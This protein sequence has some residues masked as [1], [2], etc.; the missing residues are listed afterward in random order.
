MNS[1]EVNVFARTN[2]GFFL[3]KPKKEDNKDEHAL[4]K[5]TMDY[6]TQQ[7]YERRIRGPLALNQLEDIGQL[8]NDVADW[9]EVHG[10]DEKFT[11]YGGDS[12]YPWA[13]MIVVA[14]MG[15]YCERVNY[16]KQKGEK[17]VS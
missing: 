7:L 15:R 9:V 5:S 13:A 16:A 2:L 17:E 10:K 11:K 14:A 12:A 8:I 1:H 4:Y 6:A 3:T